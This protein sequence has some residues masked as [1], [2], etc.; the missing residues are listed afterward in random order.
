MSTNTFTSFNTF[1]KDFQYHIAPFYEAHENDFDYCG[2]HGRKHISRALIFGECM[3]RYYATAFNIAVDFKAVRI[4]IAFHDAGRKGNGRDIWES[5]S[6]DLCFQYLQQKGYGDSYCRKVANFIS[7]KQKAHSWGQIV[8][9]ADVLEIMRLF[10]N[11]PNGIEQFRKEE[12]YFL[13]YKDILLLSAAKAPKTTLR[14]QLIEEAWLLIQM[15]EKEGTI[16]VSNHYLQ[17]LMAWIGEN[18]AKF[19]FIWKLLSRYEEE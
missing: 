4:A 16:R 10:C 1:Q 8:Y 6:A 14:T 13:S 5:E 3:A 9:D 2:I 12:L 15:T 18:S 11:T 19:P 7:Q 17:D